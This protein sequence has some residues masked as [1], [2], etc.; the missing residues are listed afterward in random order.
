MNRVHNLIRCRP[1]YDLGVAVLE[2]CP[3]EFGFAC[4]RWLTPWELLAGQ[5]GL[6]W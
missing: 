3:S 5:T 2:G 1:R 6:M 4:R